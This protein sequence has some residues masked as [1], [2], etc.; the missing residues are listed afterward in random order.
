MLR[1]L[2]LLLVLAAIA[3]AVDVWW[4]T[5]TFERRLSADAKRRRRLLSLSQMNPPS[6]DALRE[7]WLDEQRHGLDQ[8]LARR[9]DGLPPAATPQT[10]GSAMDQS[11]GFCWTEPIQTTRLMARPF[12]DGDEAF[13]LDLLSRPEVVRWLYEPVQTTADI[14]ASMPARRGRTQLRAPGDGLQLLLCDTPEGRPVGHVSLHWL[15]GPHLQGEVGFI[16]HPDFQGRG[17]ATEGAELMLAIGFGAVGL[18]RIVGRLEA[19]NAASA[20]VLEHLG[21]RREAHLQENEWVKGEWQDEVVYA[22]LDREWAGRRE[23]APPSRPS[24]PTGG[25]AG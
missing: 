18:H 4:Q 11:A 12:R 19:R 25:G 22:L 7:A 17:Y 20:R 23:P 8:M 21:M 15:E 24:R 5:G 9:A 3:G 6:V 14:A 2:E 13:L 10:E 16:V 1:G